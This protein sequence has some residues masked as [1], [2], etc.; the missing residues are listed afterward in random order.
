MN[1][2]HHNRL[3]VRIRGASAADLPAIREIYNHYVAHSTCTY[4]IEPDT[5]EKR[6][7]WFA[8]R[9]AS[10]PVIVA[11][12]DGNVVAWASLSP[13]NLR[14]GYARTV[15]ASIY[16]RQDLHRRGIGGALLSDLI[17]RAR[18]LGHHAILGGVCATQTASLA[19]QER[20]GFRQ[21]GCLREV[22]FK[23]GRW[24]DVVLMELTL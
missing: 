24:L 8:N 22:G 19:L 3:Q 4:Q 17:E 23:F 7:A 9:G 18:A 15:E 5:E 13:W 20:F 12:L 16:V 14:E 1:E 6:A 2:Q 10:H 21:V 11:E